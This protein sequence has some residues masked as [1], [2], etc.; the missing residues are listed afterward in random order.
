[1]FANCGI[2]ADYRRRLL[3]LDDEM[4]RSYYRFLRAQYRRAPPALAQDATPAA[5]L[6]K[7]LKKLA[8]RWER[9]FDEGAKKLAAYFALAANKRSDAAL[10]KILRDAGFSVRFAMTAAMRDVADATVAESVSLIKSIPQQFHT[11]VEGLVMR[12]VTAGRDLSGL[13][14]ELQ[15]RYAITRRRAKLIARDQNAKATA[16]FTRVRQQEVGIEEAVWLHSLGGKEPRRT[17][18]ANTGKRY[19]IAKGWFDPDPK[20]SRNI[21]PGELINCFPGNTEVGL[22]T[23]PIALWRAPFHGPMIHIRVGT[24]LLKGTFHHPILTADGWRGLGELYR[25]DYVVCMRRHSRQVVD[26]DEHYRPPTFVE[27][28]EAGSVAGIHR[29]RGLES[30]DFHGDVPDGDVDEII[31]INDQLAAEWQCGGRQCGDDIVLTEAD[32]VRSLHRLGGRGQVPAAFGSGLR[33]DGALLF[34]SRIGKAR[35]IGLAAVPHDSAAH[36]NIPDIG[37]RVTR[38][39]EMDSDR[40]RPHAAFVERRDLVAESVPIAPLVDLEPNGAEL[41]AELVRIAADRGSRI[42]EFGSGSYEFR[43]VLDKNIVDFSGH[44][45][46]MQTRVGYYSVGGAFVQAKN[47]RCVSKSVV[48]GFS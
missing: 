7:E 10:R 8:V 42:F 25:G 18:L 4:A 22:E 16:V 15:E 28:F 12:S 35:H 48:K 47:C 5:E 33:G 20:V 36:Q 19:K 41:F 23:G 26:H 45:F 43:R 2:E 6:L 3:A 44:V 38:R 24:D 30:C 39:T 32:A 9:R 13:T 31:I 1:V 17:H 37:C 29:R 11:E 27:L 34:D 40:S 21:W 14:D 46:T